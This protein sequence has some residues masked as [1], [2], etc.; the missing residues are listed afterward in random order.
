MYM[1]HRIKAVGPSGHPDLQ[2]RTKAMKVKEGTFCSTL[3]ALLAIVEKGDKG[4][5]LGEDDVIVEKG[6]SGIDITEQLQNIRQVLR[7]S[8]SPIYLAGEMRTSGPWGTTKTDFQ[9]NKA[10]GIIAKLKAGVQSIDFQKFT[11]CISCAIY[12]PPGTAQAAPRKM[13]KAKKIAIGR[14]SESN[15]DNGQAFFG[16]NAMTKFFPQM[17]VL[18]RA[19]Y[20]I[21]HGLGNNIA[22]VF[23]TVLNREQ[24][25]YNL[26]RRKFEQ[27]V[28]E[29]FGDYKDRYY[30]TRINAT[31][32]L[33][34]NTTLTL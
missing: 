4:A 13:T 27:D 12:Y 21:A 22:G 33:Y 3:I 1:F 7:V 20:D 16:V 6:A 9:K 26:K 28:L 2:E 32:T 14:D 29:R 25:N 8:K 15:G 31:L 11:I 10:E 17:D 23:Y 19:L 34:I 5:I 30:N 24:F 18:M